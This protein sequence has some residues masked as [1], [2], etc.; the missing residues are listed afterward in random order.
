MRARQVLAGLGWSTLATLVNLVAQFGFMAVLARVLDPAT[1]GLM[2]MA[3]IATRFASFFA[4]AGAA[5]TLVQ[6]K[7]LD[8]GL[9][10]AALVLT[11]AISLA[12]YAATVL[13]APL[14]SRYFA[15][16]DLVQILAVFGLT[17]PLSALGSLPMALLRRQGR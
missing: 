13:A 2:A 1:F 7:N 8:K 9:T 14:F 3:A 10:T 17:L 16:P 5:Q 15:T 11:L 12:L 6:Q 4:Q